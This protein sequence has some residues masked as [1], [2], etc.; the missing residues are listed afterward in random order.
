MT[1]APL[2]QHAGGFALRAPLLPPAVLTGLLASLE[3]ERLSLDG[4]DGSAA[5]DASARATVEAAIEHD[6]R[7]LADRLRALLQDAVVRE[8]IFIA[9][10]SL[11][12][13]ISQWLEGGDVD[14]R[15]LVR[16]V[17]S[18]VA[19]MCTRSTPFGLF[20]GS[21]TGTVSPGGTDLRLA[22]YTEA[23][24]HTRIDFGFLAGVLQRLA[25]DPAMQTSLTF[26]PNTGLYRAGGRL[27]LAESRID[28]SRVHYQRVTFDEDDELAAVLQRARHG[29]N[30]AELS[31]VIAGDG[32]TADDARDYIAELVEAQVLVA[33]LG[34]AI[35]GDEPVPALV[36]RLGETEAGRTTADCLSDAQRIIDNLDRAGVGADPGV[37]RLLADGL[38][39][40]DADLDPGQLLQVDMIRPAA[41][42]T[43][44][45]R[46]VTQLVDAVD[47][48]RRLT[49]PNGEDD[50]SR[51][52][53]QFRERYEDR[54]VPLLEV[55][56]EE[57][58]I[59]F[60]PNTTAAPLERGHEE[61]TRRSA[62]TA[63]DRHRLRLLTTAIAKGATTVQLDDA[64]IAE[65]ASDAPPALPDALAVKCSLASSGT[66]ALAA[67][68]VKIW[69]QAAFGP[70]GA[71]TLGRFCHADP[72]LDALVRR[73]VDE[74]Q[75][76]RPD[77]VFAEVVH[78]AEGRLGNV[79]A[80][81]VLRR[82]EIELH[83][84]SG[85]T[86]EQKIPV[87]DL[88][89][90]VVGSRIVLRSR[91]LGR[92]VL[93]RLTSAHAYENSELAPYRFLCELQHQD[94]A[95]GV[96]WSWGQL[97]H[98]PFLPRVERGN[99][100]LSRAR[101][102][103]EPKDLETL[104]RA[105][106][107]ADR[108]IAAQALR[109]CHRLPRWVVVGAAD[110]ELT[111]DLATAAG[112]DVIAHQARQLG[113][114][115]LLELFPGP[116]D[117]CV[118]SP[119]GSLR[120]EIAVPITRR[121]ADRPTPST[122]RSARPIA[123]AT[124]DRAD[125]EE[126]FPPGSDWLTA[127]L[128]TGRATA[129]A[130]V[131]DVVAPLAARLINGGLA[132]RWF[133]VR[134]SDPAW[135][136]RV[137]FHGKADVVAGSALPLLQ[138]AIRPLLDDGRVW[139]FQLDT[140]RRETQRYGG[141]LA[142]ELAERFFHADSEAVV[143]AMRSLPSDED[144]DLRWRAALVG[145]DRQLADLGLSEVER[146]AAVRTW[147]DGLASEQPDQGKSARSYAGQ[148]MR[149]ERD[150]LAAALEGALTSGPLAS[151]IAAFRQRSDTLGPVFG[152][153]RRLEDLG[154]LSESL[155][156]IAGS[157]AHMHVNRILRADQRLQ[158]LLIYDLLDRLYSGL[159]HR[160]RAS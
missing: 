45:D 143:A 47:L 66:A 106:T 37:Y 74:E 7:V 129:D 68:D 29:A 154:E 95:G 48:L 50:L 64:D 146:Q 38:R 87:D 40:L 86:G 71:R 109:A 22:S 24:R 63:A 78:L 90:S 141:P 70:S 115:P 58:G 140:Y 56:D 77:A 125:L 33:D 79:L 13:R 2:Y 147:R 127:K 67:G 94:V 80:R 18:Y 69:F 49:P 4:L 148:V 32:V 134:Y 136:L 15:A 99:L 60:G 1:A 72:A 142:I 82:Y 8:A 16:S 160:G 139:R 9:S 114:L 25:Q 73:H 151:A 108:V 113:R 138:R 130:L 159:I 96:A 31:S 88:M 10:P 128:Y 133:F 11:D 117:L 155:V 149:R 65:L 91:S 98:A 30:L 121:V 57:V 83:G 132:D 28:K 84:Q 112:C 120:H 124:T 105:K 158:E 61:P 27:R 97:Q 137:R 51:F 131:R 144:K 110:H 75:G 89:V 19:R 119:E 118:E 81:P 145:I 104:T 126:V 100:V 59:G 21:S 42:L 43:L 122:P 6:H 156:A 53:E 85:A 17:L 107:P 26:R 20:A 39:K 150:A 62:W 123:R 36:A 153:L 92:E 12:E 46:I 93:P 55:L 157:Y 103:L 102:Q 111:I 5:V 41:A 23:R 116:D 3:T 54:E 52:R 135:H 76:C 152:E 14:E 35:T 34:P 101:W 44:D